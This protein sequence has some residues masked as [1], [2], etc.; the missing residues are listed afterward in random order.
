MAAKRG[1]VQHISLCSCDYCP[2]PSSPDWHYCILCGSPKIEHHHT[3][4]IGMGGSK[5]RR[6]NKQVVVPL[7]T[8]HHE[9]MSLNK[10]TD[11]IED[12]YY[13]VTNKRGNIIVKKEW[14]DEVQPREADNGVLPEVHV[15]VVDDAVTNTDSR[16]SR[17]QN[18]TYAELE[19][20]ADRIAVAYNSLDGIRS[21]VTWEIGDFILRAEKAVGE[22][23]AQFEGKFQLAPG[24]L[25][26]IV[27]VCE[28][29]SAQRRRGDLSFE[30]HSKVA[31]LNDEEQAY[32]LTRAATEALSARKL[33]AAIDEALGKMKARVK[34]WTLPELT[35]E[36]EEWF[37]GYL[38]PEFESF[39]K[40]LSVAIFLFW[41]HLEREESDA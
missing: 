17:L 8:A 11:K 36:F 27:S 14:G 29:V 9:Q 12:G 33:K 20:E 21:A 30:H 24:R 34:R 18:D 10:Y 39:G 28:R 31:Y 32:W 26:N 23:S 13:I 22:A 4:S 19:A 6:M 38:P 35:K 5:T 40:S 3:E 1:S 2:A 37:D 16:S 25:Q 7:C 41:K 15:E